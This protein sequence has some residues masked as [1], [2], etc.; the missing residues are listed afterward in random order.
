M[1]SDRVITET[2]KGVKKA[3]SETKIR[4]CHSCIG[5]KML[6]NRSG[7]EIEWR[8]WVGSK[9]W[10]CRS[11]CKLMP[12]EVQMHCKRKDEAPD[13]WGERCGW[14][15]GVHA[16]LSQKAS[17]WCVTH[18][19]LG[20]GCVACHVERSMIEW[21][22]SFVGAKRGARILMDLPCR[23]IEFGGVGG[24]QK[25]DFIVATLTSS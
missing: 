14:L 16:R 7:C 13:V 22:D 18:S 19:L 1:N 23:D 9:V 20:T 5:A 17:V 10:R 24:P 4:A 11:K 25:V 8:C 21:K 3:E 2:N 15:L 12:V 6:E